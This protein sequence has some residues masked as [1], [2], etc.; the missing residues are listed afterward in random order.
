ML[1]NYQSKLEVV[2]DPDQLKERFVE[3]VTAKAIDHFAGKGQELQGAMD[4]L[5]ALKSKYSSAGPS[6]G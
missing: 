5:S 1:D 6:K 4:Q 2:R 3:T